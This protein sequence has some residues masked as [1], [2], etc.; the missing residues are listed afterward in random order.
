MSGQETFFKPWFMKDLE[1]NVN[2]IGG[3]MLENTVKYKKEERENFRHLTSVLATIFGISVSVT[4]AFNST[5]GVFLAISWIL[6]SITILLGTMY[7]VV[8]SESKYHRSWQMF[9]RQ[10]EMLE[11]AEN[12]AMISKDDLSNLVQAYHDDITKPAS[13]VNGIKKK[14]FQFFANHIK[15]IKGVFYTLFIISIL[16]LFLSILS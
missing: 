7:L 12:R 9:K 15:K 8:E 3:Q 14:L 11:S 16:T 13:E 10:I 4:A 2:E 1:D 6:Q 5:I